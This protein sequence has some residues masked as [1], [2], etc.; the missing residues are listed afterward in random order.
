MPWM[1]L[2]NTC[3]VPTPSCFAERAGS[4]TQKPRPSG[5]GFIAFKARCRLSSARGAQKPLFPHKG[6]KFRFHGFNAD[7]LHGATMARTTARC[8]SK[9]VLDTKSSRPEK[10]FKDTDSIRLLFD[11][12][13]LQIRH[14]P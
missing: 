2:D 6:E 10:K 13:Q 9:E 3:I 1:G 12:D 4:E 11:L 7:V 5:R 14:G 8:Q